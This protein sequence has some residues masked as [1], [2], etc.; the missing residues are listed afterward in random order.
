MRFLKK[1]SDTYAGTASSKK[2][3]AYP[4]S[5][6]S[7]GG[8]HLDGIANNGATSTVA[9]NGQLVE[10]SPLHNETKAGTSLAVDVEPVQEHSRTWLVLSLLAILVIVGIIIVLSVAL[11]GGFDG[12]D[13]SGSSNDFPVNLDTK[14]STLDKIRSAGVLRAGVLR[15]GYLV[16][17]EQFP[18]LTRAIAGGIMGGAGTVEFEKMSFLSDLV[19][20]LAN[21]TVDILLTVIP[22]TMERDVLWSF[23]PSVPFMYSGLQVAG[24]HFHVQCVEDG[25]HHLGECSGLRVCVE[26]HN[27]KAIRTHLPIGYMGNKHIFVVDTIEGLLEGFKRDCNVLASDRLILQDIYLR[28]QSWNGTF[29]VGENFYSRKPF[30]ALTRNDD[31]EFS[32]F[33]NAIIMGLMAAEQQNITQATAHLLP[34]T[35][36]FGEDYKDMFRNAISAGGNFGEVYDNH[37]EGSLPRSVV[38]SINNGTTGLLYPHPFGGISMDKGTF[39]NVQGEREMLR[40]GIHTDRP[41]FAAGTENNTYSGMDVDYC[42]ALA[43]GLFKGDDEAV[44]FVEVVDQSDGYALLA[45]REIDVLT[46]A[47]WTLQNDVKEPTTNQGY[48]FS[49]PYFYGYSP[50]H[51]NFCLATRQDDPDWSGF[52]YWI[53][54]STFY[55]EEHGIGHQNSSLM[56]EVFV[57]G[58]RMKHVFRDVTLAVGSYAEIYERNVEALIPRSGRNLLNTQPESQ[59]Y[60]VP[61]LF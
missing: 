3:G 38:D 35:T 18:D 29:T 30:V 44:E 25:F 45:S 10:E 49:I 54:T 48:S 59:H 19:T 46:G 5:G 7:P 31:P 39:L 23:S 12:D 37:F 57:Y 34:Q 20:S 11:S 24:D 22:H 60:V 43:V 55:A 53:V 41:G 2:P 9:L 14:A 17:F 47:T 13:D 52:V 61:G 58:P 32:D 50:N 40:C 33:V 16:E 56:P 15:A 26:G 6:G 51:D 27:Y 36:L 4:V 8:S 42:R 21:G 1:T 28:T